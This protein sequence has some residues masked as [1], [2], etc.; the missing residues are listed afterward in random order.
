MRLKWME[1]SRHSGL[2]GRQAW[3]QLDPCT[4]D[5]LPS[6]TLDAGNHDLNDGI[7]AK[8]SIAVVGSQCDWITDSSHSVER[9]NLVR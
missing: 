4:T 5:V 7:L 8:M 6:M 3:I 9:D 2:Q 1:L